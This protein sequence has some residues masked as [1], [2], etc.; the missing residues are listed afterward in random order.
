MAKFIYFYRGP[1]TSLSDLTPQEGAARTAA[2]GAW[3]E[4]A[5]AALVDVGGR[6]GSGISVRDDGTEEAAGDL[7]GYTIVEV[8]DLAA[9]KA[10]TAGLPFLAG[11]DGKCAVEI[12]ELRAM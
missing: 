1:A 6:F 12:F 11:N 4:R 10:L 8:A 7:T 5:G 3:M 2:F 9:A